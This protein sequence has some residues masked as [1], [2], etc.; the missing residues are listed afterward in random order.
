MTQR[1]SCPVLQNVLNVKCRN[2][3]EGAQLPLT[4]ALLFDRKVS[5]PESV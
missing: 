1:K 4:S 3:P 2:N 5:I